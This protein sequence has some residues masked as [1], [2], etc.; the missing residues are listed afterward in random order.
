[1][2]SEGLMSFMGYHT[3]YRIAGNLGSGKTPLLCLHG[4]P[5][6]THS[7]FESLDC[8][9]ED[10]AVISYDQLGC[11]R[12]MVHGHPELWTAKTWIDELEE[13]RHELH[14]TDVHLLG[15]SWGGMLAISYA[16]TRHPS[17]IRSMILSS[18]LSS[19]S[20]WAQEQHRLIRYLPVSEQQAIAEAEASGNYS[21]PAYLA[22]NAHYMQL[23]CCDQH[24]E[25]SSASDSGSGR[26]SYL[27]AW[28]PNEYTPE[29]TL[30]DYDYTDALHAC[31]IPSLII[32]GTDDL[33]TPL[34]AK[35]MKDAIPDSQWELFAGSR[36][37]CFLEQPERYHQLVRSWM[38]AHDR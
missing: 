11:G 33:C 27:A 7:Y 35:T 10:R 38:N 16:C 2:I 1:M 22:A 29:G 5:G 37:M 23:H 28:G 31:S 26:E 15:Q 32:S 3:Y 24:P 36:H 12:S 18:T 30:K 4:G 17:G 8:L 25:R 14:L 9:S 19:A 13:L 21:A 20:L 6:S 34:I